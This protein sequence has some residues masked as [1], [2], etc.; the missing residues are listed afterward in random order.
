MALIGELRSG[1]LAA[2]LAAIAGIL[3]YY[4]WLIIT[5]GLVATPIAL[6]LNWKNDRTG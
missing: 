3:G 6:F 2:Q 1:G 5:F 4:A